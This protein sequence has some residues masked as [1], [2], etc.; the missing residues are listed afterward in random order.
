MIHRPL[1]GNW[2]MITLEF[3][4]YNIIIQYF[5]PTKIPPMLVLL[6]LE[7]HNLSTDRFDEEL[8]FKEIQLT[9]IKTHLTVNPSVS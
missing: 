9:W 4:S 3:G 7:L 8:K 5:D 6:T 1:Y 2:V